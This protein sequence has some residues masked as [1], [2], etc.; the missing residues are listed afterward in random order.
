MEETKVILPSDVSAGLPVITDDIRGRFNRK[1]PIQLRFEDILSR[2]DLT[3]YTYVPVTMGANLLYSHA[4]GLNMEVQYE[5]ENNTKFNYGLVRFENVQ[6]MVV[7]G[8]TVRIWRAVH[9]E[10]F[11]AFEKYLGESAFK[12]NVDDSL[13]TPMK[14]NWASYD[15]QIHSDLPVFQFRVAVPQHPYLSVGSESATNKASIIIRK[16]D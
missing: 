12:L 13:E 16:I 14:V 5:Q 10:E 8:A 3:I 2:S 6:P 1:Q 15:I 7:N 11:P 4:S 9:K